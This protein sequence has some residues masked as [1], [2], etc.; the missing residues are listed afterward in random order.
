[1]IL[2]SVHLIALSLFVML[3]PL[4]GK[5]SFGSVNQERG[6]TKIVLLIVALI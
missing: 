4:A 6:T 2:K 1:M 5:Y 3:N